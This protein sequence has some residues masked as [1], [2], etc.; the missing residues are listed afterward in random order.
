MRPIALAC[1]AIVAAVASAGETPPDCRFGPGARPADT[2]PSGVAHGSQIPIDHIVVLM[3]ENR[4]F[5]HYF[6]QMN[7]AEV[8]R[9]RRTMSNPDP[10]GGPPIHPFHQTDYCEVEDLDHGWD[11]THRE[12]NGGKMDGFTAENVVPEDPNGHRTMGFYTKRDLPYYYKLYRTFA[13]SDRHF[14]SVL[15]PT[16]PNRHYLL[17]GTSF[18]HISNDLP[19]TTD[20]FDQ[21]SVFNL[22]DEA[23]ISW[24]VY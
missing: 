12:W 17:T 13:M 22:L 11:G 9:A 5:D 23:G 4:S 2:L 10:T 21:R 3:Q 15:G 20:Q 6:S 14:C 19:T 7:R 8:D 24:K 18:G 16:Y 1:L